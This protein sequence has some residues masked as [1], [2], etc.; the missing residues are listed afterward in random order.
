M[1][2]IKLPGCPSLLQLRNVDR[3]CAKISCLDWL[4]CIYKSAPCS[5][6]RTHSA[7]MIAMSFHFLRRVERKSFLFP[8]E[9]FLF[10]YW[11]WQGPASGI[12]KNPGI[13]FRIYCIRSR[14]PNMVDF[15]TVSLVFTV[16]SSSWLNY[17]YTYCDLLATPWKSITKNMIVG[18]PDLTTRERQ[19]YFMETAFAVMYRWWKELTDRLIVHS[20]FQFINQ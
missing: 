13:K 18:C 6:S 16:M 4:A 2:L 7:I 20:P 5:Q 15:R 17:A 8:T 10:Y 14:H 1:L 12:S 3:I 11:H 19:T 9:L